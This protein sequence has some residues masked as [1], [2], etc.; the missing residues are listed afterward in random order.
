M[1]WNRTWMGDHLVTA[2]TAFDFNAVIK[3]LILVKVWWDLSCTVCPVAKTD[4]S[5]KVNLLQFLN[6]CTIAVPPWHCWELALLP[7]PQWGLDKMIISYC[8]MALLQTALFFQLD[9]ALW[10]TKPKPSFIQL[11]FLLPTGT[12]RTDQHELEHRKNLRHQ[13]DRM[14]GHIL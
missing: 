5:S 8:T 1:G 11:K 6:N 4:L 12:T 9:V 2:C 3:K 14:T 13:I 7:T 10:V